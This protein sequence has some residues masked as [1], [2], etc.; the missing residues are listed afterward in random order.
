MTHTHWDEFHGRNSTLD[1]PLRWKHDAWESY[2]LF[3]GLIRSDLEQHGWQIVTPQ[4]DLQE[5]QQMERGSGIHS[6]RSWE[7][8]SVPVPI[9]KFLPIGPE[10]TVLPANPDYY[11]V[12]RALS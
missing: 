11:L 5:A 12:R 8:M 4:P 10:I 9:V 2:E 1:Q 6:G 7:F 3:H